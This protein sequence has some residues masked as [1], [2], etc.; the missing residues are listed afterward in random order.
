MP[1]GAASAVR[2]ARVAVS[3]DR[4]GS[5]PTTL[6]VDAPSAAPA[7]RA[8]IQSSGRFTLDGVGFD[9]PAGTLAGQ[10]LGGTGRFNL[11]TT[12]GPA[13]IDLDASVSGG[14]LLLG[15]LYAKLPD[16]AVQLGLRAS[17]QAGA[18]ELSRLRINDAD[19]LQLDGALAFDAK[20]DL[21]TL[22]LDRL[23]A[24]FP[25]AYDRYGRAWLNTM[26]LQDMRMAGQLNGSLDLRSDGPR[27][28]AFS[29]DRLDMA[30]AAGRLAVENLHG[31]LDWSSQ[32]DRPATT[33]GWHSLQFYRVANG[34]ARQVV[35]VSAPVAAVV[36]VGHGR[37]SIMARP[38]RRRGIS[39]RLDRLFT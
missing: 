15:P 28:F 37:S 25:A 19:A 17:A 3:R 24:S 22:K 10:G 13:R 20:G 5:T 29:T 23:H 16:H 34:A 2:R 26:G 30:D 1:Y 7:S 35:C 21:K 8:G 33:L 36:A 31:G 32:G 39:R 18:F 12:D 6:N 14:E 4:S 9:T 38:P 11:D 27:S